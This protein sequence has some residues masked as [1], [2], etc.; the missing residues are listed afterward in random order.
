MKNDIHD[1]GLVLDSRVKLILIESWDEPR[2]LETLTGLAVKRGLGLHTWSVT[3]GLQRLGFG[4]EQSDEAASQEPEA[5]LRLIKADPQAN[6]YVL[7]DLHPFLADD[8]RLVRLLKEIA[9]RDTPQAPTL[10]LV[11]HACKLPAEVQRFAARFSL[12]LPS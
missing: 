9:M 7:C 5:A 3:E 8:P 11:S 12:A 1:L 6:L 4:V 10:V 2:V